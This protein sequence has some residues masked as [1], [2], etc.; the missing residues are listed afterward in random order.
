VG[1]TAPKPPVFSYSCLRMRKC[2]TVVQSVVPVVSVLFSV[3]ITTV[4]YDLSYSVRSKPF[5][6]VV[7]DMIWRAGH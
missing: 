4:L 5:H 3:R 2:I 1:Q 6:T 7:W